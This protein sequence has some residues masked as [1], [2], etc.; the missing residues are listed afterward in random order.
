V[1]LQKQF[2]YASL[3]QKQGFPYYLWAVIPD[4]FANMFPGPGGWAAF[5]LIDEG[6]GYPVGFALQTV[7][8]PGLSP[9]CA[10][11]HTGTYRTSPDSTPVLVPGAPAGHFQFDTFNE[12]IFAIV[13]DPRFAPETLMPA[14][15]KRFELSVFEF[16][17]YRTLLIPKL[18]DTLKQQST[19]AAWITTRPPAGFGRFDAFNLFK[20]NVLGMSDDG[21]I[22]TVDYPSLWNQQARDGLYVHW[23]GSGNDIRTE[24]LLSTYPVNMGPDGFLEANF[25]KMHSFVANLA[26]PPFPF[27]VDSVLARAGEADFEAYCAACH[28]FGGA[29]TGGVTSQ[30]EIGTDPHFL[31]VWSSEFVENLKRIDDPPF[32][33]PSLRITNGYANMPLDG[34]WMRALSAQ[35]LGADNVGFVA[36]G[37][38]SPCALPSRL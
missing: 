37:G 19:D 31:S 7:G 30:V 20:I 2:K 4:V 14:I 32:Q 6:R 17:I 18:R 21:S 12:F 3:G 13:E 24:H 8:F 22:G 10:L 29:K 33:F 5:G 28:S 36:V 15:E 38:P 35:R 26:P 1:G 25:E 16:W 9:N 11:C 23:N 27:E 34:I